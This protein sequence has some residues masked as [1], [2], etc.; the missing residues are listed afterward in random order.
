MEE[1]PTLQMGSDK[2]IP[3]HVYDK[4]FM[5][6]FPHRSEWKEGFQPDGKEGLIWCTD[7]SKTNTGTGVG[8]YCNGTE[9][10][11]SFSLGR[12]TTVFQADIYAIKA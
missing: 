4:S 1:E 7:S 3:K 6:R 9:R 12:Y 11:L 2:M 5:F 8:M 10:K